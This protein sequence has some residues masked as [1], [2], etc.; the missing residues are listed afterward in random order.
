MPPVVRSAERE[1]AEPIRLLM[2]RVIESSV[3]SSLQQEIIANVEAN[4]ALWVNGSVECVHLV[5]ASDRS[6]VGVVLVKDFWNLCSLFVEKS[7]QG[8]GVGRSLVEAAALACA[9]RSPVKALF[10]NAYPSAAPFYK[11]LGFTPRVSAQHLPP[12]I[13]AMGRAFEQRVA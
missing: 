13:Q 4:L 8:H 12:G 1:E 11:R 2:R 9:S 10:L 6:I 3:E 7:H 5:A